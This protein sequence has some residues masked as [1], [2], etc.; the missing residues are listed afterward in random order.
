MTG[1]GRRAVLGGAGALMLPS[2]TLPSLTRAAAGSTITF[3]PLAD[4]SSIDPVWTTLTSTRNH[5]YMVF[6]TLFA[7]DAALRIQPQMAQGMDT[8][9][10]GRVATI[11]LRSGLKWHDNT[12]V[13]ARDCVASIKRWAAR[14]PIGRRLLAA[15][16]ALTAPDDATI[17]FELRTPF[18]LLSY[19]LGKL[20]TPLPLMMPASVIEAAGTGPIKQAI[21]SGPFRF[22]ASEWVTGSRAVYERF[23]GYVPRDEPPSGTAGGKRVYVDRVVWTTIPDA[24]T[25]AGALQ[26]G[27]ADWWEWPSQDLVPLLQR[28]RDLRVASADPLGFETVGWMNHRQAPFNNPKVRQALATAIN[29]RDFMDAAVGDAKAYR[30]CT[31]FVPCGGPWSVETPSPTFGSGQGMPFGKAAR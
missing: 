11:R 5:G 7:T 4:M 15:T 21:G 18:P 25:A 22:V 20:S 27:S 16:E 10:D 30:T 3:I 1:V 9:A 8:S 24:A 31:A 6:D 2:L 29:Q 12:P 14:D 26:T 19:A 28:A 17:R 13:L 23:D